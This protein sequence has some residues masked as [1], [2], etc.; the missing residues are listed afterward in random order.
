M[1]P[2]I[3]ATTKSNANYICAPD[4]LRVWFPCYHFQLAKIVKPPICATSKSNAI[5]M[6]SWQLLSMISMLSFPLYHNCE[7][8]YLC[9]IKIKREPVML[10]KTLGYDSHVTIFNLPKSWKLQFVPHKNWTRIKYIY[11]YKCSWKL[12]G[13]IH[14][15]I[16]KLPP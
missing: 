1:K 14:V 4:N 6:C 16:S 2:P 12:L 10:L 9:H 11:I 8:S 7:T 15:T 5:H 13:M 3:C